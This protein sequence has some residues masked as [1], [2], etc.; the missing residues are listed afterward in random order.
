MKK[1]ILLI[2]AMVTLWTVDAG[3]QSLSLR[4]SV[5]WLAT[6]TPNI[7]LSMPVSKKISIHLPVMYNPW[8]MKQNSRFQQLTTMPGIRYWQQ[9]CGV[10]YFASL[11][12]IASRFHMGGWLDHKYRYD[13]TA[14]GAGIGF[15]YSWVLSA[16][17][18]FE[19]EGGVG[20]VW[21][22]YDK[23]GWQ[24][25]SHRYDTYRGLRFIPTK[26]DISVAYFF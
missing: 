9:Q 26:L 18:N 14:Y 4:T 10:H 7:E 15:G 22:K 13:G 25:D 2:F 23:C 1:L 16:H 12:G 5:T 19:L 24:S 11:Y 21:A 6:A 3:A 8:V 20:C 17:W